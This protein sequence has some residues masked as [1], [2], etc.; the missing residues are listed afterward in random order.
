MVEGASDLRW[1][2]ACCR[3]HPSKDWTQSQI[4]EIVQNG[5]KGLRDD[6]GDVDDI[7]AEACISLLGELLCLFITWNWNFFFPLINLI[8]LVF[9]EKK[10]KKKLGGGIFIEP[11]ECKCFVAIN[12]Y[13]TYNIE[14]Y[15]GL[16][17]LWR[18]KLWA[19]L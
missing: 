8:Y 19:G 7:D 18:Q 5:G 15:K 2:A 4:L 12:C 16:Q 13:K 11:H 1:F 6:S 3:I 17:L 14:L 10:K 9:I